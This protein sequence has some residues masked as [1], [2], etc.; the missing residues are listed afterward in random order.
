MPLNSKRT[1]SAPVDQLIAL[2]DQTLKT[3]WRCTIGLSLSTPRT[4]QCSVLPLLSR[5][6]KSSASIKIPA[7]IARV[8]ISSGVLAA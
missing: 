4:S 7:S 1:T 6:R 2:R 8:T 3:R 5:A